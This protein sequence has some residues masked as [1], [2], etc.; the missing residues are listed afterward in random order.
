MDSTKVLLGKKIK[1]LRKKNKWTQEHLSELVGINS[2]SIL[3]IE[4]GKTFPSYQNLEKFA[5]IF[6]VEVADLF[7]NHSLADINYLKKYIY[8]HIKSLDDKRIRILYNFL[9]AIN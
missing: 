4:C 2:K 7:N 3:R 5:K 1:Q 6:E 8:D 9:Y